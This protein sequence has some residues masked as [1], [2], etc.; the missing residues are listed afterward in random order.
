MDFKGTP[1]LRSP[2]SWTDSHVLLGAW[3]SV[4][5]KTALL[6]TPPALSPRTDRAGRGSAFFPAPAVRAKPKCDF[7]FG[8][9]FSVFL[10]SVCLLTLADGKRSLYARG[11]GG[12][13][14]L[15][16]C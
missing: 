4:A 8:S 15:C 7:Q 9:R 1:F 16:A 3:E 13:P 6:P 12:S 2:V 5:A 11:T 14:Q 10:G